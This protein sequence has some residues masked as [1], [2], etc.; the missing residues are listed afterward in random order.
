LKVFASYISERAATPL[1]RT[2]CEPRNPALGQYLKPVK[3]VVQCSPDNKLV[4]ENEVY[5][6]CKLDSAI[7]T[8]W[9]LWCLSRHRR[10]GFGPTLAFDTTLSKF[11]SIHR[12]LLRLRIYG[13]ILF[14]YGSVKAILLLLLSPSTTKTF[15]TRSNMVRNSE[16]I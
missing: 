4:H 12:G 11:R 9:K 8:C 5:S 2:P 3:F 1:S 16:S 6:C 14:P 7:F 13:P 15:E 10:E